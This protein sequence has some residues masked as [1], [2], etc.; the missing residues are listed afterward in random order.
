MSD[1]ISSK[2]ALEDLSVIKETISRT[3]GAK[4]FTNFIYS[5]GTLFAICGVFVI[6]GCITNYLVIYKFGMTPQIIKYMI[7]LWIVLISIIGTFDLITFSKQAKMHKMELG[8][9]FKHFANKTFLQID[10][11]LETLCFFFM[12]YFLKVGQP[13][14]ILPTFAMWL[15][16][17]LTSIGTIYIEKSFQVAGYIYLICGG[18]GLIFLNKFALIYTATI[19]GVL[20]IVLGLLMH[21]RYKQLREEHLA[22][23][24]IK[25]TPN[26]LNIKDGD[27]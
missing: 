2:K 7:I 14:Y 6:L 22:E 11:P 3:T 1:Q 26:A 13:F 17:L 12:V 24:S 10:I 25:D 23:N 19:F 8:D 9:Y 5:A 21:N 15:G 27:E 16:V 4:M 18:I 20:S